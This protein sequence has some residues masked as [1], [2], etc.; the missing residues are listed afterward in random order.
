VA[1]VLLTEGRER[2]EPPTSRSPAWRYHQQLARLGGS[3]E[4]RAGFGK[5]FVNDSQQFSR[6]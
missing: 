1:T 4:P 6:R 5:T 3:A 2:T